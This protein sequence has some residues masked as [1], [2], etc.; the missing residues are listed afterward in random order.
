MKIGEILRTEREKRGLS[1]A[2]VE[3]ATKIRARYLQALEEERFNDIPGEAYCLGF[4]RNY[5]RF[6]DIDPEPLIYDMRSQSAHIDEQVP[7]PSVFE[8]STPRRFSGGKVVFGLAVLVALVFLVYSLLFNTEEKV[9]SPTDNTPSQREDVNQKEP[10]EKPSQRE[11]IIL[12]L[13]GKER[14]NN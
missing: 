2:E 9:P 13:T 14:N 5:A 4:L 12:Q 8:L 3:E 1:L 6:L 7:S 10:T 11:T